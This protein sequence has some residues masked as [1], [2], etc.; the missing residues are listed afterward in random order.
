MKALGGACL[1]VL[2]SATVAG[3]D[4][5]SLGYRIVAKYP[6]DIRHFTEGLE[7]RDGQLYESTGGYGQSQV[8]IKDLRTGRTLRQ[9]NLPS[10]MFGEGL[11]TLVDQVFVLTWR[12]GVGMIFDRQ[13]REKRRF[14]IPREGWGL[15]HMPTLG[16]ERLVMS[17][18]SSKLF[19][20]DPATLKDTGSISVTEKAYPVERLNE[21]EYAR[22]EIYANV[23]MSPK[24][25]VIQTGSGQVR[26]WVDLSRLSSLF[27]KPASWNASEHVLNGIAFDPESGHFFVTGKCWPKLFEIDISAD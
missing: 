8:F 3:A 4:T 21:L 13:L 1:L 24:I 18:G 23:W 22:G 7:I 9:L 25:A 10:A 12:E 17:D 26:A 16:G 15:T 6:H 14:K 27:E 20:L 19:Q 11:T 2:Y 5:P